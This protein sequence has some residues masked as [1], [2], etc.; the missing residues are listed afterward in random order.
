MT[1]VALT[2]LSLETTGELR[3]LGSLPPDLAV[4]AEGTTL[5]QGPV[6][7]QRLRIALDA[8]GETWSFGTEWDLFSGQLAG[9]PW[10]VPGTV[11][12][13]HREDLG[14]LDAGSFVPRRVAADAL[15]GPVQVQ[16]GLVTS[17][18]G[19]GMLANDG[20]HDP[21]FGRADFGDRVL[22]VRLATRPFDGGAFPL[23]FAIAGDRVIEDELA[24]FDDAQ[25]AWQGVAAAIYAPESGNRLGAYG[26]YR[27][28]TEADVVRFTRVGLVDLY[29]ELVLP[30]G[31]AKLRAGAEAAGVKGTTSRVSNYGA[32]EGL[33]V[34]SAGATG[35]VGVATEADRWGAKVRGGWASGDA[36]PDDGVSNDFTFDRDYDAG[37]LLFDEQGGAVEAG[38]HALLTDLEHTGRA[39]DGVEALVTEGSF[40]RATFVQPVLDASPLPWLGVRVGVFAAWSTAPIAQPYYTFRN[41]GVATNHLDAPTDGNALGTELDWAVRLG[42]VE[43]GP[44]RAR[45]RPELLVQGAHAWASPA[46]GGEALTMLTATARARW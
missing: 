45:V 42:G 23:T 21:T 13:R 2:G 11:D 6:L 5:G 3:Y 25:V 20:A 7:D 28:Q 40:R 29:G 8:K 4:D 43:V 15:L 27:D 35:F 14:V 12:A 36:N 9:D 17:N 34:L 39:P 46:M 44:E 41:G 10:D 37:M 18:W 24:R 38:T 22:R 33:D 30:L 31:T 26:V 32:P 19:L 1:L 16:A